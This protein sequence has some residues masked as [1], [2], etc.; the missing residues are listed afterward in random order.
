MDRIFKSKVGWW[1][2]L[3]LLIIGL[4]C[5]KLFVTGASAVAMVVTLLA[6]LECVHILLNTWY[7]VTA[8]G[9]LIVH[10]SFFPEKKIAVEEITALE[11]SSTPVSSYAL[12][13][14][15][16]IIWKGDQPWMLI[17]PAG[18]RDFVKLLQR[19][20]PEITIR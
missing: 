7:K 10:C 12:S 4:L 15:R 14:D 16:L 17:S 3:M 5:V 13:F 18:K 6:L 1:Y 19:M 9:Y 20:N 2:H 11:A 8:D